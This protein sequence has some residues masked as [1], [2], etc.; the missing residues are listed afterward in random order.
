MAVIT[1]RAGWPQAKQGGDVVRV[2]VPGKKGV[3]VKILREDAIAQGLLKEQEP[4]KNKA[5]TPAKTKA[6]PRKKPAEVTDG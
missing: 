6:R 1:S 3:S 5:R 2:P 4:T